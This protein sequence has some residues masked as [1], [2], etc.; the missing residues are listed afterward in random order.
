MY[1]YIL[2]F[3][4]TN[5]RGGSFCSLV[6]NMLDC[7]IVESEFELQSSYNVQVWTPLFLQL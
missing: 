5:V 6:G 7:D 4:N 1:L 3:M 2:A